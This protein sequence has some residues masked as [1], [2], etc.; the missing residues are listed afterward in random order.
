MA[1][2]LSGWDEPDVVRMLRALAD[3]IERRNAERL[4]SSGS[5]EVVDPEDERQY[6]GDRG[7]RYSRPVVRVSLTVE[8]EI[9]NFVIP[10]VPDPARR[11][12][13]GGAPKLPA[14]PIDA[15]FEDE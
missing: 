1:V 15:T 6:I 2:R 8:C 5:F 7:P 3:E 13:E 14:G 11:R 4:R 10:D 9:R 12:L